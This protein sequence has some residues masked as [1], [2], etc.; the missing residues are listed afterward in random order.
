MLA[1]KIKQ[2]ADRMLDKHATLQ[3]VA[4]HI[5][6]WTQD[7]G[8]PE[9]DLTPHDHD[10]QSGDIGIVSDDSHSHTPIAARRPAYLDLTLAK[11]SVLSIEA[12]ERVFG[13]WRAVP[14]APSGNPYSVVFYYPHADAPL[15][16]AVFAHLSGPPEAAATRVTSVTL[17]RDD[18]SDAS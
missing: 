15:S 11:G 8:S 4:E 2:L 10:F 7:A 13:R 1:D 16:V 12:L 3:S 18:A 14:A 6:P 5:G 17:R 9:C